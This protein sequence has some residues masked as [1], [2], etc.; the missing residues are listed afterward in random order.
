MVNW[1]ID[2]EDTETETA[3]AAVVKRKSRPSRRK[4]SRRSRTK[5]IPLS[6]KSH[7]TKIIDGKLVSLRVR[8]VVRSPRQA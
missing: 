5:S 8:R 1:A 7:V 2:Y 6:S 4:I 3:T